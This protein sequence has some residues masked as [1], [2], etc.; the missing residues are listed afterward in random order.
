MII[1]A[2][3]IF[4]GSKNF[5]INIFS[6]A[7]ASLNEHLLILLIKQHAFENTFYKKQVRQAKTSE[8]GRLTYGI[9]SMCSD[10]SCQKN[11][12]FTIS[13][14]DILY[15]NISSNLLMCMLFWIK[16]LLICTKTITILILVNDNEWLSSYNTVIWVYL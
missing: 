14:M 7:I 4:Q 2:Q 6:V 15:L 11:S 9:H 16:T 10:E 3:F 8:W 1:F 5:Q 13:Y 12:D